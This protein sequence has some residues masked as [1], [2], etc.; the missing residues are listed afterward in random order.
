M[1][2]LLQ[3]LRQAFVAIA[4]G[5]AELVALMGRAS[6]I[7]D[8]WRPGQLDGAGPHLL[9]SL[10]GFR[11][12]PQDNDT[13]RGRARLTAIAEGDDAMQTCEDILARCEKLFVA[14][15]FDDEGLNAVPL[16]LERDY[17]GTEDGPAS[18]KDGSRRI[19]RADLLIDLEICQPSLTP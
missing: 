11:Q 16:L 8:P 2:D 15:A 9:L 14:N 1:P 5:D 6:E 19:E 4:E 13:R 12:T 3:S 7:L 17:P 18:K 10:S